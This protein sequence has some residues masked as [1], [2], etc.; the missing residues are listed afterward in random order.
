M[1]EQLLPDGIDSKAKLGRVIDRLILASSEGLTPPETGEIEALHHKAVVAYA[2]GLAEAGESE[3]PFDLARAAALPDLRI[4]WMAQHARLSNWMRENQATLTEIPKLAQAFDQAHG[5][6][7]KKM[8]VYSFA[9]LAEAGIFEAGSGF[10]FGSVGE[11]DETPMFQVGD[12]HRFLM[13]TFAQVLAL[14]SEESGQNK[15]LRAQTQSMV[16]ALGATASGT[17]ILNPHN[18]G[19]R[20][21]TMRHAYGT[22]DGETVRIFDRRYPQ[23]GPQIVVLPDIQH[24]TFDQMGR[25]IFGIKPDNAPST[26]GIFLPRTLGIGHLPKPDGG[27]KYFAHQIDHPPLK[28]A[29]LF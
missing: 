3:A 22:G 17:F 6:Q 4:L 10:L 11:E 25:D 13:P 19:T 29:H 8:N 2:E 27:G 12:A 23:D 1:G 5:P 18:L 28:A 21:A 15:V 7:L 26:G 16:D 9:Q 24:P 20:E 14:T